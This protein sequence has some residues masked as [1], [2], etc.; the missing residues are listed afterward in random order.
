LAQRNKM[1]DLAIIGSRE[2]S[3]FE[4]LE[5]KIL[6]VCN[7]EE[8]SVLEIKSIV[9]GGAKGADTL[10]EKFAEKYLLFKKIF[11]PDWNKFG[12]SAGFRRNKDIIENSD[13]VIA[14]WDSESKGTKHSI[15]I[16]K[17]LNKKIYIFE[18]KR[19]FDKWT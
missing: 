17:K 15:D 5:Q 10:A 6:L 3:D 12:K 7:I 14:F 19:N 18:Y 4:Y 2:F 1:I 11:Y 9:S 13:I 16:S 8:F